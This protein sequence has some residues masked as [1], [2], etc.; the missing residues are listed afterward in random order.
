MAHRYA[1]RALAA[2]AGLA[3]G[4]PA[5][6][7]FGLVTNQ[8]GTFTDISATGAVIA[9]G[10]DSAGP[11]VSSVTNALVP[12]ASLFASTN[13]TISSTNFSTYTNTPLPASGL[14]LA[15]FPFWDDLYVDGVG[16]LKHQGVVENG[17]NVEVIQ[18]NQVRTF[19]AGS[20]G[21]RGSFEVKLFASGPVIAQYLYQDMSW[22]GNGN[23]STI[24]LQWD[25]ISN[26]Q[27]S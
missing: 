23:S 11:F 8:P 26:S 9:S 5:L 16:S 6:A 12:S 10:D 3:M 2:A 17:I 19:A 25:A 13:G 14:T 4:A 18:W 1:V 27:F 15:M 24:G 7:Q 20:T 21:A 22:D